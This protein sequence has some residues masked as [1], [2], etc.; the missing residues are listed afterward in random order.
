[1]DT[2]GVTVHICTTDL[3]YRS[4]TH[5]MH[6]SKRTHKSFATH[7]A[8]SGQRPSIA[9]TAP[10]CLPTPQ[11]PGEPLSTCW[12]RTCIF[13]VT[14]WLLNRL[15]AGCSPRGVEGRTDCPGSAHSRCACIAPADACSSFKA[16]CRGYCL[17]E[18]LTAFSPESTCP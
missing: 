2:V 7:S 17:L 16:L 18:T 8:L 14:P 13:S 15:V 12:Q 5:T 6:L 3:T 4:Y 1:M 9:E 11:A 10:L